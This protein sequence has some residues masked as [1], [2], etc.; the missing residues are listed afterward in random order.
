MVLGRENELRQ[1]LLRSAGSVM[2]E[3]HR[4]LYI[5]SIQTP[6]K[7]AKKANWS[8]KVKRNIPS[9]LLDMLIENCLKDAAIP[10]VTRDISLVPGLPRPIAELTCHLYIS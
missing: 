10:S 4:L 3:E 8:S 5:I 7:V 1:R 9:A 2:V 6:A